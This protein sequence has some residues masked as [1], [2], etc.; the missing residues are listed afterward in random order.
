MVSAWPSP[1]ALDEPPAV[2]DTAPVPAEHSI[3][4]Q[5]RA[6]QQKMASPITA[7][8]NITTGAP[9]ECSLAVLSTKLG[10]QDE[11]SAK[12]RCLIEEL[13]QQLRDTAT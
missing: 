10:Q 12:D 11:Q 6:T 8:T 4:P 7:T 1:S 2:D 3:K 13:L 9:T 5:D